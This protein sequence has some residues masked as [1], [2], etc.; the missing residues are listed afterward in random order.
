MK[1]FSVGSFCQC[2][3]GWSG[4]NCTIPYNCTCSSDSLCIGVLANNRSIC[5]CPINKWGSRCLLEDQVC[6]SNKNETCR[7]G[8]QCIYLLIHISRPVK[9][10][11]VFVQ[12]VS[13]ETYVK[14]LIIRLFYLLT[15]VLSYHQR[16]LSILLK[17]NTMLHLKTELHS[18]QFLLFEIQSRFIGHVHFILHLSNFSQA[19]T[20]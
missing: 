1:F 10:L 20:I 14:Y 6:Q 19:I 13:L 3:R 18:E 16:C 15:K 12:K 8:G 17:P 11:N 2:D 7:N 4:Q 5:V 9:S